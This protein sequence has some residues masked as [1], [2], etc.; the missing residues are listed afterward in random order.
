MNFLG[1][2]YI[3]KNRN[4]PYFTFGA[5]LPDLV[6]GFSKIYNQIEKPYI[7]NNKNHKALYDGIIRHLHV[8]E[9]FHDLPLFHETC[10]QLVRML[11]ENKEI[12]MP[13]SFFVAH[14]LSELLIDKHIVQEQNYVAKT[15][16]SLLKQIDYKELINIS[17]NIHFLDFES[18]Y[19]PKFEV[20][21][22]NEYALKLVHNEN[23]YAALYR[24]CF[25]RI[26]YFPSEKQKECI[27]KCI[28][29]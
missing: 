3:D 14:I 1:H 2:F 10:D 20:F 8:D 21:I 12:A 26:H 29:E 25:E 7:T 13:R 9:V 11:S 24:I 19:L 23:V 27:L 4:A 6:R 15:Y 28:A 17:T 5:L 18:K 22:Q 16:Y